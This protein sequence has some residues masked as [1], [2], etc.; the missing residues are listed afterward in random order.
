MNTNL[1]I[2]ITQ[3]PL[4]SALNNPLLQGPLP[5]PQPTRFIILKNMFNGTEVKEEPTFFTDLREDIEGKYHHS[6]EY[7]EH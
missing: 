1:P 6:L 5:S 3:N 7:I 2:D 4:L